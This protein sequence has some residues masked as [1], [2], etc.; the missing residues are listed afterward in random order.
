MALLD[1]CNRV[2]GFA[3][4]HYETALLECTSGSQSAVGKI[5]AREKDRLRAVARRIVHDTSRRTYAPIRRSRNTSVCRL[6]PS[7]AWIR[8]ELA[9]MRRQFE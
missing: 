3:R 7:R 6:E 8:R 5:Y 1:E 9:A 2:F 4:L